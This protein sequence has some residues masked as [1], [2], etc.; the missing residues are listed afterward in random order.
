VSEVGHPNHVCEAIAYILANRFITGQTL[1][2]DGGEAINVVGR[3]LTTSPVV[4][5][6]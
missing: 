1:F 6:S 2:V 3:N 5:N 4:A